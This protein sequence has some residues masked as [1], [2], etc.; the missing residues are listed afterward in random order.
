MALTIKQENFCNYYI[1]SGNASDAYRRAYDCEKMTS[2]SIN[3]KSV[4][5]LNNGKITA[6]VAELKS[7]LQAKSD[8]TKERIL[9]ELSAIVFADIRDYVTFDGKSV[10]FKA[11]SELTNEQ[12]KAIESIKQSKDGIEL[13]LY[14][15]NWSIEKVCKMLG[16][17][18]PTKVEMSGSIILEQITGMKVL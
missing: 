8:I 14:G 16:F 15:K 7:I 4:E 5:L 10:K 9:T 1:E 18:S 6:R 3:R 17:D 12:A 2:E 11:F 13:K